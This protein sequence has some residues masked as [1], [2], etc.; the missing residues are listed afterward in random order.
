[1]EDH[2]KGS[3]VLATLNDFISYQ[4][5]TMGWKYDQSLDVTQNVVQHTEEM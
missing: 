3:V 4:V 1:M 2:Q 5:Q